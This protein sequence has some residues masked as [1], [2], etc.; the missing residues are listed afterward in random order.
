[1]LSS[2]SQGF[3]FSKTCQR[4]ASFFE[5]CHQKIADPLINYFYF[6]KCSCVWLDKDCQL[7][8]R[9]TKNEPPL[10]SL[11]FFNSIP[12]LPLDNENP[13]VGFSSVEPDMVGAFA[14]DVLQQAEKASVLL[15][16]LKAVLQN[17]VN[18]PA[19]LFTNFY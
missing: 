14:Q 17:K 19:S 5:R 15:S 6:S 11:N 12:L 3:S 1:M 8:G 2:L 13:V 4:M 10:N 9:M 7:S 16:D 18:A